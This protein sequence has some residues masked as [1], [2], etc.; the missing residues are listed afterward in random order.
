MI[1]VGGIVH[2]LSEMVYDTW[3]VRPLQSTERR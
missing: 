1:P 2:I 3:E